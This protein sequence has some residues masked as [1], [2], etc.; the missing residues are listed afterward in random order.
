LLIATKTEQKMELSTWRKREGLSQSAFGAM[1]SPPIMQAQ[2]SQYE[3]GT[4][5]IT[6]DYALQIERISSGSI[7]PQDCFDLFKTTSKEP[8]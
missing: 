8:A 2:V 1:L 7:T 4:T 3:L 6:L 5:R